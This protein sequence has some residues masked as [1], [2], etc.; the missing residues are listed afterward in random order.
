MS[1]RIFAIIANQQL[2]RL[3]AL[4]MGHSGTFGDIATARTNIHHT[5]ADLNREA[6]RVSPARPQ[7]GTTIRFKKSG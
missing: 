3:A 7:Q 4:K 6:A 5:S 1:H 2:E